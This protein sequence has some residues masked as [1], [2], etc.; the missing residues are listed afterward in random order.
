M[1]ASELKNKGVKFYSRDFDGN[2]RFIAD[3]DV[4]GIDQTLITSW[5][6]EVPDEPVATP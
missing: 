3:E 1:K 5:F 6:T 4:Q 2:Y